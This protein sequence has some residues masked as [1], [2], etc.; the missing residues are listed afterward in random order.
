MKPRTT[1]Q[2]PFKN[3]ADLSSLSIYASSGYFYDGPDVNEE[4]G[5]IGEP[6]PLCAEKKTY[7]IVAENRKDKNNGKLPGSDRGIERRV[8]GQKKHQPETRAQ[9]PE[10]RCSGKSN[11]SD[12]KHRLSIVVRLGAKGVLEDDDDTV[13]V[14]APSLSRR[15]RPCSACHGPSRCNRL[16]FEVGGV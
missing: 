4:V 16:G 9:S 2:P 1:H 6:R 14:P 8:A 7:N 11:L 3:Y 5:Q 13:A 12:S 10:R 15:I